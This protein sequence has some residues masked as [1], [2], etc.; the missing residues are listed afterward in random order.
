M[1]EFARGGNVS[2]GTFNEL[3]KHYSDRQIT[4]LT[5]L[6]GY[7]MALGAIITA[8]KVEHEDDFPPKGRG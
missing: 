1:A 3:R 5:L 4:D 8:F 7:F 6:A 2:D